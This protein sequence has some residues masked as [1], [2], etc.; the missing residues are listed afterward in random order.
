MIFGTS[1]FPVPPADWYMFS[2]QAQAQQVFA[3]VQKNFPN[4][5]LQLVD[6]SLDGEAIFFM[7]P[8][9]NPQGIT[10]WII[11]GS[12]PGPNGGTL[13]MDDYAG[14]VWDRGPVDQGYGGSPDELDTNGAYGGLGGENLVYFDAGSG[15]A[16]FKWSESPQQAVS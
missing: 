3:L 6:G 11:K 14:D 7:P 12:V 9:Q 8:S 2:T 1:A 10:V 13:F 5:K 15:L 16:E 4:A